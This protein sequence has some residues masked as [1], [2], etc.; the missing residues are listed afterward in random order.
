M[1]VFVSAS[2]IQ[3][4]GE[5]QALITKACPDNP[6][7]DVTKSKAT[8]KKQNKTKAAPKVNPDPPKPEEPD[9]MFRI[10]KH[11]DAQLSTLNLFIKQDS[12][13]NVPLHLDVNF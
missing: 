6:S 13:F 7:K 10:E 9:D 8:P 1:I 4:Q 3:L 5:I 2:H 12:F 11:F